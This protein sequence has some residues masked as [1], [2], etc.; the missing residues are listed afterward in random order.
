MKIRY[1]G[2]SVLTLLLAMNLLYVGLCQVPE[3]V[4]TIQEE[5][6]ETKV[7][8]QENVLI[9]A[10]HLGEVEGYTLLY[11]DEKRDTAYYLRNDRQYTTIDY[12]HVTH[13]ELGDC[14]IAEVYSGGFIINVPNPN[15]I[16]S[17]LSGSRI[18]TTQGKPIG[19]VSALLPNGKIDCK[20]LE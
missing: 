10:A 6:K 16:H 15:L 7:Q 20:T 1:I 11:A 8:L 5:Q 19:F 13:E 2:Q 14:I 3:R 12:Q 9:T 18:L 4:E 17:G